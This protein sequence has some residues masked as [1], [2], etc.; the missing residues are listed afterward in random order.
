MGLTNYM[1]QREIITRV[2][3]DEC[4]DKIHPNDVQIVTDCGDKVPNCP[5]CKG[6]RGKKKK[7]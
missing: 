7:G 2:E 3:C 4:G 1:I 5:T 6:K